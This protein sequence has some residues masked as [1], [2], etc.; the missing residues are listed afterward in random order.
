ME[1][2]LIVAV[3][4]NNGIGNKNQLLCHLPND[5]KYFKRITSGSAVLMGRKTF[6]SIGRPLPN[7]LN[8]VVSKSVQN[9]DGC[10]VFESI[11]AAIQFAQA[12]NQANLFIIGGDSIYKQ[13][14]HLCHK[15]YLTRIQQGFEADSFFGPI[16]PEEW[17]LVS[18]DAQLADEK[19]A[20]AHSFEVYERIIFAS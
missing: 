7:R 11:D 5:L 18:S 3:D 8:L 13:A 12:Q 17:Q 10:V 14:L 9:I 4:E 20:Y 1:I 16:Q 2:A 19:N 6:D 15:L